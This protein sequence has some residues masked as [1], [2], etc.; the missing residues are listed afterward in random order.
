MSKKYKKLILLGIPILLILTLVSFYLGYLRSKKITESTIAKSDETISIFLQEGEEKIVLEKNKKIPFISKTLQ[1]VFLIKE[2]KEIS[3]LR[4]YFDELETDLLTSKFSNVNIHRNQN[5]EIGFLY[6]LEPKSH[7][8]IIK[9]IKDGKEIIEEYA[10]L[11]ILFDDFSVTLSES[12]FWGLTASASQYN[13]WEVKDGRLIANPLPVE[14]KQGS[15]SSLFSIRRF[16]GDF[17]VQ[18]DLTPRSNNLSFLTYLF[19]RNLNFV[20]GNGNN[21]NVVLLQ[22]DVRGNF[23]FETS[24]IYHIRLIREKDI[25]KV[26]VTDKDKF[27]DQDLLL[28]YEDKEQLNIPFDSFGFTIWKGSGGVEIDN[29]YTTN[30]DMG[31]VFN[32]YGEW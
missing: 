1:P 21:R 27:S 20:F 9:Y 32:F 4:I 12:S 8:I 2:N 11:L 7:Q 5:M 10:F 22:R 28:I 30:E 26:Y 3:N 13:N 6:T 24:E 25:Y 14:A 16:Q 19:E 23:T 17:F 31:D 15:R 18:F 29:F